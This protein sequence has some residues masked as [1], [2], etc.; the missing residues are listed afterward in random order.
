[1]AKKKQTLPTNIKEYVCQ[2]QFWDKTL[3]ERDRQFLWEKSFDKEIIRGYKRHE[4]IS[5]IAGQ[6]VRDVDGCIA[7]LT[8]LTE[9]ELGR[10]IKS[11]ETPAII[12]AYAR[13][14]LNAAKY[15]RSHN[16]NHILNRAVGMP[17]PKMALILNDEQEAK[18]ADIIEQIFSDDNSQT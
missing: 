6:P 16:I 17:I 3:T 12:K 2:S 5:I 13:D 18:D 15:G 4:M 8:P 9:E 14:I 10:I 7:A 1:M 11:K